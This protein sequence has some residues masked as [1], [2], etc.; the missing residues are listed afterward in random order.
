MA[1][2]IFGRRNRYTQETRKKNEVKP[3][4]IRGNRMNQRHVN[5]GRA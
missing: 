4:V 2:G 5:A 1:V 3:G